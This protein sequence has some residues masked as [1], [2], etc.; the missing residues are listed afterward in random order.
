VGSC[1]VKNG[2]GERCGGEKLAAAKFGGS[3]PEG[4]LGK[5]KS[6]SSLSL[7]QVVL[8]DEGGTHWEAKPCQFGEWNFMWKARSVI[9]KEK[10][11]R[12]KLCRSSLRG[13]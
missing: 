13:G 12:K 10:K 9:R 4:V 6:H 7:S 2:K 5:V 11:N 1:Q 8:C 3:T